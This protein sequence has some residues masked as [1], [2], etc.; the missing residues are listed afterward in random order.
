MLEVLFDTV[1]V[2]FLWAT[3]GSLALLQFTVKKLKGQSVWFHADDMASPAELSTHD[4]GFYAEQ[5]GSVQDFQ[6]GHSVLPFN[7]EYCPQGSHMEAF[8]LLEV[9]PVQGPGLTAI[10]KAREHKSFAHFDIRS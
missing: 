7:A 4:H 2:P 1:F 8:K 6:V 5:A 3:P 9:F 10:E